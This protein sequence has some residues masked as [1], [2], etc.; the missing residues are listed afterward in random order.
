MIRLILAAAAL[1]V[2]LR[3]INEAGVK[4]LAFLAVLGVV[5]KK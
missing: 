5:L 1:L 4:A 3:P 2:C